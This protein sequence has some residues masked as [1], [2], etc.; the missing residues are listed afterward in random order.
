MIARSRQDGGIRI[1][2]QKFAFTLLTL[3]FALIAGCVFSWG[4]SNRRAT[5]QYCRSR[6]AVQLRTGMTRRQVH[7][8]LGSPL[9]YAIR[10]QNL[11]DLLFTI[12]LEAARLIPK[13]PTDL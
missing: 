9:L 10:L 5:R 12:Q 7:Y 13:N 8:L 1:K 11:K 6:V 3:T 2:M 4:L